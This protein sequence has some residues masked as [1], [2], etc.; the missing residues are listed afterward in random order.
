[1]KGLF[2]QYGYLS[3][4]DYKVAWEQATFVF[5]TNVLLN[6]YRYGENTRNELLD[7]LNKFSNR[8]WV[9]HHV[10]LEFQRNRLKVI[11]EQTRG[12][13]KVHNVVKEA[14]SKLDIELA[15]LAKTKRH[16]VIESIEPLFNEFKELADHFLNKLDQVK[17]KQQKLTAPDPLKEKIEELFDKKVGAPPESQKAIDDLYKEA[18]ERF[19]Y[20]IPPGYEDTGKVDSHRQGGITYKQKYGDYLIW[21]QLLDH[22]KT[23]SWKH[24]ILIT[25][26]DKE[27]WWNLI[28]SGGTKTI[29]PRPELVEEAHLVAGIETF[30]MYKSDGFLKY[31]KKF[32][33][34]P[35]SKEI[36]EEVRDVSNSNTLFLYKLGG[37]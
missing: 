8:I 11:A 21:K 30:L 10:A 26:D 31:A 6:F 19:K 16:F 15:E 5:D 4:E 33:E 28:N 34:E 12:F 24:I 32:L 35:V 36:L 2:P 14:Q 27:D 13:T 3:E 25:D 7:V 1:M 29:G 9:S 20:K 22:A 18:E 23:S 37:F 17:E